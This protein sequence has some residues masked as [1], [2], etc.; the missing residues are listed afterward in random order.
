MRNSL[1]VTHLILEV[2]S[3]KS[4]C[5]DNHIKEICIVQLTTDE[6]LII[7]KTLTIKQAKKESTKIR[8]I[9]L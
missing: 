1:I 6:Y 5:I 3:G 7:M 2:Y 4:V 9:F 8:N